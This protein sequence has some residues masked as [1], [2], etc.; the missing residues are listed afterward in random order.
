MVAA[1]E[2]SGL[3][4]NHAGELSLVTHSGKKPLNTTMKPVGA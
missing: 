1:D 2:V 3:L 4:R